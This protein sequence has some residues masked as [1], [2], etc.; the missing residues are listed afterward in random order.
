MYSGVA[1]YQHRPVFN[2]LNYRYFSV[3]AD[4]K[5]A[6]RLVI[7]RTIEGA[8]QIYRIN[9]AVWMAAYSAIQPRYRPSVSGHH[10]LH[11]RFSNASILAAGVGKGNCKSENAR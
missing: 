3:P 8:D 11:L 1:Q 6:S 10:V 4:D 5:P 9:I 2:W 7:L